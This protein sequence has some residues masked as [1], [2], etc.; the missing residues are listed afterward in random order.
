MLFALL[1]LLGTTSAEGLPESAHPYENNTNETWSWSLAGADYLCV[2]FSEDTETETDCDFIC[3]TDTHGNERAF[4]G[5][6][7]A[8]KSLYIEGD[9][10]TIQLTSNDEGTANGFR[11]ENIRSIGREEF[12]QSSFEII[13]GLVNRYWGIAKNVIIPDSFDGQAVD[14]IGSK[15]FQKNTYIRNVTVPD[16]VTWIASNA[17]YECSAL[18]SINLPNG[19][20]DIPSSCFRETA[21]KRIIIPKSVTNIAYYAFRECRELEEVVFEAGSNLKSIG[22]YA[23]YNCT[24]LT[25]WILP[26]SVT[27]IGE[28]AFF[29]CEEMKSFEIGEDSQLAQLGASA[30]YAC[31]TLKSIYIPSN[32]AGLESNVFSYCTNLETVRFGDGYNSATIG[33]WV[34]HECKALKE[35]ILP[36]SITALPQGTFF[37]CFELSSIQMSPDITSVGKSCFSYCKKLEEISLSPNGTSLEENAFQYCTGLKSISGLINQAATESLYRTDSLKSV[38]FA[39]DTPEL[40][41]QTIEDLKKPFFLLVSVADGSVLHQQMKENGIC[42]IV[43]E[44]G[45]TN[46]GNLPTDTLRGRVEQAVRES[47]QEGM[48]DYEKVLALHDWLCDNAAYD[49]TY[50]NYGADGVLLKGTG[51]CESYTEAFALLMDYIGVPNDTDYGYDHTWNM[52][53]LDGDWYH[54]DVTWDDISGNHWIFCLPNAEVENI[55]ICYK[56]AHIATAY[57]YHY[58]YYHHELDNRIQY[59]TDK[60][61]EGLS[62]GRGTVNLG[63]GSGYHDYTVALVLQ[64][65]TYLCGSQQV[66]I[67]ITTIPTKTVVLEDRGEVYTQEF[68]IEARVQPDT[69]DFVL[70]S[71]LRMIQAEAFA[72]SAAAV[73]QIPEGT[74]EIG[75]RAFAECRLLRQVYVPGSISLI[76]DGAFPQGTLLYGPENSA[77]AD[78]A[79][80]N[81]CMFLTFDNE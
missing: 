28:Y 77:V 49:Y 4:T 78:W 25:S 64:D 29:G 8:G 34:F 54:I 27:S 74:E 61:E 36:D 7:L 38:A 73:V 46:Q 26:D 57:K 41:S 65:Q 1:M 47:V 72:G 10:F 32:L 56:K 80:N 55:H 30:F 15:A 67:Q 20:K 66:K 50:T 31:K 5:T 39:Y 52:V 59:L 9:S 44:T 37:N 51:V 45:E 33:E 12:E 6:G 63:D 35:I 69:P 71:G 43:R 70:P 48:S 13:D 19:I 81:G 42:Y 18:E 21:L 24:K 23:F 16:T 60:I 58:A 11:V 75:E 76:G 14:A 3:I 53:Q 17:F 68:V 2:T 40:D 62:Q 79:A 22:K